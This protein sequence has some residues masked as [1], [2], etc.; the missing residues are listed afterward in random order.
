MDVI[1]LNLHRQN[2]DICSIYRVPCTHL[3][4]DNFLIVSLA[5][6]LSAKDSQTTL[7]VPVLQNKI[8]PKNDSTRCATV[9]YTH[10]ALFLSLPVFVSD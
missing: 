3:Y 4:S 9:C 7:N 8:C 10:A 2:T 5:I 1:P 6:S